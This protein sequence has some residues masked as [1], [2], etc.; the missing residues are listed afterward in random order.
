VVNLKD[1]Y[2]NPIANQRVKLLSSRFE[3]EFDDEVVS[4]SS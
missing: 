4:D 2:L 3:D 1:K